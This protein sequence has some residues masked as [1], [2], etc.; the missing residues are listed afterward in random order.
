MP[1]LASI[2]L[3]VVASDESEQN[4]SGAQHGHSEACS[5][6]RGSEGRGGAGEWVFGLW[7][8]GRGLQGTLDGGEKDQGLFMFGATF[9]MNFNH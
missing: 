6:G 7:R 2:S 1:W 3:L 5:E 4:C 8:G 9:G